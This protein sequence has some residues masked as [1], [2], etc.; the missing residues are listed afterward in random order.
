MGKYLQNENIQMHMSDARS[1]RSHAHDFLEL[2]YV[3]KGRAIHVIEN[4]EYIIEKGNYFIVDFNTA[5]A[6]KSVGDEPL[7]VINCLFTPQLIDNSLLYCRSF[8]T[9]LQHYLIKV[10]FDELQINPAKTLF[11][12]E[13]GKILHYLEALVA[14]YDAK[15][16]GFTEMMRSLFIE[17]IITTM[18]KISDSRHE[19]DII[20]HL[21]DYVATHYA[22]PLTL[23]GF[24]R[25]R[26]YSLPYLSTHFKQSMGVGFQQ[27]L[28]RTRMSEACR[29]L[30]NT[31]KK[32]LDIAAAVGYSD[33]N[34]FYETFRRF[35]GKSPREFRREMRKA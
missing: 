18:R 10:D 24:A 23:S 9:L 7:E 17:M 3:S 2:A 28:I 13:D 35:T 19:G 14:E 27:Y 5:H 26:G 12:D 21:V 32:I 31:D 20:A 8:T 22:E 34:F 29:L 11:F 16:P 1:V 6:Y 25:E 33:T 4:R 30:A 15:K